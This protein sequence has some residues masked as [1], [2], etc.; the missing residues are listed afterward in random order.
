MNIILASTSKTKSDILNIVGIKHTCQKSIELDV[1]E[2]DFY[3]YAE[4]KAIG[5]A[6]SVKDKGI[7]IGLDTITIINDKIVEKPKSIE[8]A[9]ENIVNSSNNTTTVITGYGIINTY[10]NEEVSGSTKTDITFRNIPTC[11]IDYY[12]QNEKDAMYASGFIL[13]TYM[14]NFI[15]E[16][17][18]SYY[19][20]I[21][22]PVEKIYEV[23][24]NWNIHL[25]DIN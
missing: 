2:K 3:K 22:V 13:E 8:E 16:I 20:I 10:T 4:Q 15:K 21:G 19:N 25:K 17:K 18:G 24:E 6:K 1:K 12:I 23:L 9:R 11:D 5:K 14:S 7:I